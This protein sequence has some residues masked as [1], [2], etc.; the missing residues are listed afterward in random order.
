MFEIYCDDCVK[1]LPN[2]PD[3]CADAIITDPPYATLSSRGRSGKARALA[4]ADPYGAIPRHGLDW[5]MREVARQSVR[6]VKPT[7]S[8]LCF[9]DDKMLLHLVPVIESC[10]PRFTDVVVWDKGHIGVGRGFRK[11]YELLAHFTYGSPRYHDKSTPNVIR[12]KRATQR[13]HQNQKPFNLL[14]RLIEVVCPRPG[15]VLD[16]FMGSGT[17]GLASLNVGRDFIGAEVDR[18]H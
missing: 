14:T 4:A 11:Q 6:L 9:C 17:V 10:G 16:P 12:S 15:V 2:L 5:I 1:I 18:G 13:R 3:R 7:G 8:L